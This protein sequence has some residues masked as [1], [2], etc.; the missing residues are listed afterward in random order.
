MS[1][2]RPTVQLVGTRLDPDAHRVRDFLTRIA[3][4]HEL[5]EAGSPEAEALLSARG[6]AGVQTPALI[7]GDNV[8]AAVTVTSLAEAWRLSA[9]P[10]RAHYHLAIVGAGPA[11]LAAAVYA[12]SDGLS[13]LL[14]EADVPGG[15]ASHT[16]LIENFFGFVDGIGTPCLMRVTGVSSDHANVNSH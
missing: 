8:L 2:V 4:P 12:A 14:I 16:S 1:P 11:G 9:P 7:D 3:Q 15:Q 5:L 6:A 10:S 13:T